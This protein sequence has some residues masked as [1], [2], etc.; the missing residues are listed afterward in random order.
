[1]KSLYR[2]LVDEGLASHKG[3]LQDMIGLLLGGTDTTG[4]TLTHVFVR[5]KRNPEVM[6]KLREEINQ[7]LSPKDFKPE[8]L[9]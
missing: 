9:A 2:S 5:L 4:K 3:A 7:K 1:M 8:D 6:D